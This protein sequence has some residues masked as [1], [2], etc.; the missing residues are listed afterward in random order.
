MVALLDRAG[1]VDAA[2][3]GGR[4]LGEPKLGEAVRVRR[5]AVVI[6]AGVAVTALAAVAVA[7]WVVADDDGGTTADV[8]SGTDAQVD[9]AAG[10]TAA[11]LPDEGTTAPT[12]AADVSAAG[13][14]TT[15]GGAPD[16]R[17]DSGSAQPGST[18]PLDAETASAIEDIRDFVSETRGLPFQREV[19]VELLDDEAFLARLD[20]LEEEARAEAEAEGEADPV[21]VSEIL[22]RALRILGP[23]DDLEEILDAA[24][25]EGTLGFYVPAD[26]TLVVRGADLTPYVRQTIAHELT[27]ALDDQHFDIDRDELDE[28]DEDAAFA[29]EI[30]LEGSA[31]HVAQ[32]YRDSLSGAEQQA[33]DE[34]VMRLAATNP[35]ED[36]PEE[37]I[38]ALTMPY[39]V[40]PPFVADLE[41]D[42]GQEAVDAAM[43]DPP[44]TTEQI[45]D[46]GARDEE[47]TAVPEPPTPVEPMHAD[48][49]GAASFLLLFP[50]RDGVELARMWGGDAYVVWVDGEGTPCMRAD[51]VGD[52]GDATDRYQELLEEWAD[53]HGAAQ[54]ERVGPA[55]R[56]TACG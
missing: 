13:A 44:S 19:P 54:V 6:G 12:D 56:L 15:T 24:G 2:A 1:E 34:E 48:V 32:Q 22:L 47:A 18:L 7:L 26:G 17:P 53:D 40:G 39:I 21:E 10:T 8:A 11:S 28:L 20:Q 9:E 29:A 55:A 46:A 49:L 45:L 25:R 52:D 41:E 31:E 42:G 35:Y 14:S 36:I 37:I 43:A 38:L 23:D 5:K 50:D 27:H 16:S 30:V 4:P 51:V 33:L 3:P